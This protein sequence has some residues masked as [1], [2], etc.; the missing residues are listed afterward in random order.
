MTFNKTIPVLR[1]FSLEK[2]EA[3]YIGYLGFT[4]D[5]QHR[6][7]ETVTVYMKVFC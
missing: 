4:V 2:A 5:W 7:D 1:I 6:F 3:F